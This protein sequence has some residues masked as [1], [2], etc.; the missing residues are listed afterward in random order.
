MKPGKVSVL[1]RPEHA[2]L[3]PASKS[4]T[5]LKG[6]IENIVYFGTDTHYHLNLADGEAFTVRVQNTPSDDRKLAEGDP[7]DLVID[8]NALQ[9]LRD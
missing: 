1:V 3:A 4:K 9:I 5:S 6:E 8:Q 7:I 2:H